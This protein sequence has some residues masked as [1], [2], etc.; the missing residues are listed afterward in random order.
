MLARTTSIQTV[1]AALR[2]RQIFRYATSTP[3]LKTLIAHH[4]SSGLTSIQELQGGSFLPDDNHVLA[5]VRY[6]GA[7]AVLNPASIYTGEQIIIVKA[8]GSSF[9]NGDP[10]KCLTCGI[11]KE[12]NH[13]TSLVNFDYPQAFTDGKRV[14]AN[15]Y[16]I[17]CGDYELTSPECGPEQ[18][19]IYQIRLDD[20][21]DGSG[22]GATL[23]ELRIHPDQEHIGFN[24]FSFSGEALGQSTYTARLQFNPSPKTGLPLAPRY[25]LVH[26]NQL[27]HPDLPPA[28]Y[29]TGNELHI[30]YSA[31]T[32]GEL[33]GFSGTGK[34]VTYVGY[35]VESCNMDVFAADLTTGHVR[36][37]TTHPGYVDPIQ[38]SPDDGA[39]IIMDTRGSGR[40]EF[41]DGMRGIPPI[42]DLIT[43]TVCSSVRNNGQRRFFQPW[44][45]DGHGDRGDYY[46]QEINGASTGIAGSG[47]FDDPEWNGGADPWFSNDGT[48]V[49]YFQIQTVPPACGG[50]NPLPCYNSTEPGGRTGRLMVA[51]LVERTPL[52]KRKVTP[53]PDQISWAA[54]YLPGKSA[55]PSLS[56]RAGNYTLKGK[57]SGSEL[58]TIIENDSNTDYKTI[59]VRFDNFSDDGQAT[60]HGT[61]EVSQRTENFT[62]NYVDWYSNLTREGVLPSRQFT[63]EGG[64]HMS[65]DVLTN[66]FEANGTLTTIA[67]GLTFRQPQ[68]RT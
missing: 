34:E 50:D 2:N 55:Q 16:I 23:R 1:L 58:I 44:L 39:I 17:D 48:R 5:K 15:F 32:V 67:E 68:D 28:V 25:D 63:I 40:T 11:P 20:K 45:L 19:S 29:S 49:T 60:F 18:T 64:F 65:I 31:I 35:S 12:N 27:L 7:P 26:V 56:P 51:H 53:A 52:S 59:K 46:G 8:D 33:R 61:L 54:P 57:F 10:W 36:R 3:L 14:M 13:T 38:M 47:G 62:V 30:N 43:T 41:M 6:V 37:L 24:S 21:A 66:I 9:P 22:E 4:R 42:T